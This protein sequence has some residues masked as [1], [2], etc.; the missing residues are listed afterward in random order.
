MKRYWKIILLCFVAIIAIGTF[1]IRS[2]FADQK[3]ITIAFEKVSGNEDEL[4]DLTIRGDYLVGNISYSLQIEKGETIDTTN[5][6]FFEK[7]DRTNVFPVFKELVA[8]YKGFFRSKALD[9]GY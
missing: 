4:N 3:N 7:L 2:G 9:P 6:S 5:R 1:Y 8:N